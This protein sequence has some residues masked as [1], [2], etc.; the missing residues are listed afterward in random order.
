MKSRIL[1][2]D[3]EESIRFA[4]KTHLSNEG[5]EVITAKDYAS[6]VRAIS[7]N[8]LDLVISDIILGGQTGIDIL[9]EIKSKGM[10]CPVIMITG[11]PNIDRAVDAVRFDAFD[12][13][14]KPIR[15]KNLL[16]VTSHALRY[17]S[18]IN[19]KNR[20]EAENKKHRLN[21]D[22]IFKSLQDAVITVDHHMRVLEV[23]EK[24]KDICNISSR[25]V[26]GEDFIEFK[27]SCSKC[28]HNVL[29]EILKSKNRIGE[30]RIECRHQDHPNQ[31]ALLTGSPLKD[32][33][34][35]VI[36]AVM[37]IRDI[38][39][40]SRLERELKE[41]PSLKMLKMS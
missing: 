11:E 15:K 22:A 17:K 34:G 20:I 16:R 23:N 40:L 35:S 41:R 2:V 4:F 26:I 9:H 13:L 21:L 25:K 38:T 3:D 12:Y 18:L 24:I 36:G 5:Y 32:H 30:C 6:G 19:D 39:R 7:E 28:C 14:S 31:V 33:E 29:K 8:E 10:Q 1:V 37:V 27:T